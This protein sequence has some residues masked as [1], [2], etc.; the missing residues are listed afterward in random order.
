LIVAVPSHTDK[1]NAIVGMIG[2]EFTLKVEAHPGI[3]PSYKDL[4][5]LRKSL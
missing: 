2:F 5:S 3:E 4:Q 1:K